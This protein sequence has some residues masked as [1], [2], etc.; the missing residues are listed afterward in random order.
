MSDG[1]VRTGTTLAAAVAAVPG[2]ARLY[3]AAS[4]IG[5]VAGAGED[6]AIAGDRIRIRLGVTSDDAAAQVC[7]SVYEVARAWAR[8]AGMPDA[9]IEVTAAGIDA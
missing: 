9:V 6:V 7:R 1:D 3:P 2:V 5:R 8:D 4:L